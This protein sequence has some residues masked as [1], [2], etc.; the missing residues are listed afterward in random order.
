MKHIENKKDLIDYFIQGSKIKN[1]FRIGTEHE[2][3][4]FN[5]K[6]KNCIPYD[7]DISI[8]KKNLFKNKTIVCQQLIY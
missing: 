8:L 2:K 6:N 5:L 3:F 1:S 4:L 7:G